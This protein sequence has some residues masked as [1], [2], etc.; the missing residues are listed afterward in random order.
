M[1]ILEK[2]IFVFL[3]FFNFIPPLKGDFS[4]FLVQ[5]PYLMEKDKAF[6]EGQKKEIQELVKLIESHAEYEEVYT[7]ARK[8]RQQIALLQRIPKKGLFGE[9]RETKQYALVSS[10][11]VLG[12]LNFLEKLDLL[13]TKGEYVQKIPELGLSGGLTKKYQTFAELGGAQIPLTQLLKLEEPLDQLSIDYSIYFGEERERKYILI[14]TASCHL[15][16]ISSKLEELYEN[17][18]KEEDKEK[19]VEW[20]ARFHWWFCQATPCSRGSASIGEVIAQSLLIFKSFK[21]VLIDR[22]HIDLHI[23]SEEKIEDFIKKYRDFYVFES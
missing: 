12:G 22:S 17:V 5:R 6:K 23:F 18:L 1:N 20:I 15:K 11:N 8:W 16:A 3:L 4:L 10:L 14:H 19:T 13:L 2:K 21:C 7:H 9:S